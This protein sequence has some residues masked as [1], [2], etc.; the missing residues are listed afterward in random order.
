MFYLSLRFPCKR[1]KT[2]YFRTSSRFARGF[3]VRECKKKRKKPQTSL[4]GYQ[5]ASA[6]ARRACRG[7]EFFH[8][9]EKTYSVDSH[10]V[11]LC[12]TCNHA[13]F[14]QNQIA[15][16]FYGFLNKNT[17]NI[18]RFEILKFKIS[19]KRFWSFFWLFLLFHLVGNWLI[20]CFSFFQVSLIDYIEVLVVS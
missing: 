10:R 13:F 8:T 6:P 12:S 20:V 11:R 1:I 14:I 15:N 17:F 7:N 19:F 9:C 5:A 4:N 18:H 2:V 3:S 16:K